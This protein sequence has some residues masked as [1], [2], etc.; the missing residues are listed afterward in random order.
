MNRKIRSGG[1]VK[2]L[3]DEKRT[4]EE[5]IKDL[6]LRCLGRKPSQRE[7]ERYALRLGEAKDVRLFL[8]DVFWS[9]LNSKEFMFN[10]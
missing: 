1:L 4:P 7:M 9:L 3:L 8:E 6:Y 5:I 2:K 10:H